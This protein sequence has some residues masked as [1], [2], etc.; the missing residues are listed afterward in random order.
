[1]AKAKLIKNEDLVNSL[2]DQ[3]NLIPIIKLKERRTRTIQMAKKAVDDE[4]FLLAISLY[5]LAAKYSSELGEEDVEKEFLDEVKK[6]EKLKSKFEKLRRKEDSKIMGIL[7]KAEQCVEQNNYFDA[8][9]LYY[10]AK[11]LRSSNGESD[12]HIN[13][14][15]YSIEQHFLEQF[16][17][18][19]IPEPFKD[20]IKIIEE[21][22]NENDAFSLVNVYE[23][24]LKRLL[25]PKEEISAIIYILHKIRVLI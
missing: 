22:A 17:N 2:Q 18:N 16:M 24:A 7:E 13:A 25:I 15:N 9:K 12:E 14:V 20:V 19:K 11:R 3:L 23:T 10:K 8:L 4:R 1:M 6:V 21:I 5:K